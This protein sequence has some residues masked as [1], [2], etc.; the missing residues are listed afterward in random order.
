M[1]LPNLI[2]PT[3]KIINAFHRGPA[4]IPFWASKHS[5]VVLALKMLRLL[6]SCSSLLEQVTV[7]VAIMFY[8]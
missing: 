6:L 5:S 8:L 7:L 4:T 2:P 3:S 1:S